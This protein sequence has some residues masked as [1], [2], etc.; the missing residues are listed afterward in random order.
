LNVSDL[1]SGS[2]TIVVRSGTQF[3]LSNWT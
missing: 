3:K 1:S 2:Y